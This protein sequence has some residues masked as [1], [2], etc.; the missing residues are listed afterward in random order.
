MP[1]EVIR[2]FIRAAC[3]PLLSLFCVSK[4]DPEKR[5]EPKTVTHRIHAARK[6][7]ATRSTII[8]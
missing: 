2:N 1:L 5:Y 7:A 3:G 6:I 8:K 4:T